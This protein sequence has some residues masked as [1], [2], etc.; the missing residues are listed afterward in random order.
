MVTVVKSKH[1]CSCASA[2]YFNL[3][4]DDIRKNCEFT[5]NFNKTDVKPYV[6]DGGYQI[7]PANWPKYKRLICTHN[8]NIPVSIPS[9]PH[10]LLNR[11]ILC[12]SDIEAESNFLESLATCE[13]GN[14]PHLEMYFTVN[15][16]IVNYL[17]VLNETVE[18]QLSGTGQCKSKYVLFHWNLLIQVCYRNQK[19]SKNLYISIRKQK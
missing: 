18:T 8:N 7:I 1:K 5:F 13:E 2:I 16:A 14:K 17:D 3:N 9:H 11:S 4:P 19:H 12:N 15:L 10:V 6:L